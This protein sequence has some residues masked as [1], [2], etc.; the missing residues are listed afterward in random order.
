MKTGMK[1]FARDEKGQALLLAIILLLVGGLIAAPLLA[2]MG[3]GILTGEVYETRTAE[4]Y[5]ADAGVTYGLWKI[6]DS[7]ICPGNLPVS[8]NISV[9]DKNVAATIEYADGP[10]KITSVAITDGNSHTTVVSYV[11]VT[12]RSLLDNAITSRTNVGLWNTDVVGDVQYG[13]NLNQNN[14]DIVGDNISE[15]YTNWP[16]SGDLIGNYNRQVNDLEPCVNDT[17]EVDKKTATQGNPYKIERG[18]FAP[19]DGTL[20]ITGSGW[21]GLNGTI[22]VQGSLYISSGMS[23]NLSQQTI[24]VEGAV[25]IQ[26]GCGLYG[27]GCIVAIRDINFQPTMESNPDDFVFVMSCEGLVNFQPT[28]PHG[29]FYGSVAGNV[30]VDLKN[31]TFRWHPLAEGTTLNFPI[32][33]YETVNAA[34]IQSWDVSQR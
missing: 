30:S 33:L 10:Y 3:T 17:I 6:K 29:T 22:Y 15:A 1:R 12:F 26:P 28:T 27:S 25:D 23:I 7:G 21:I 18:W 8:Y 32:D 14:S 13:G 31:S 16:K 19:D 11:D 34:T 4:L 5:A 9:N 24:F 20:K 2:Y